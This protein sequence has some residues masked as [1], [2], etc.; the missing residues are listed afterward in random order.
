MSLMRSGTELSQFLKVV[1]Y[2]LLNYFLSNCAHGLLTSGKVNVEANWPKS[3]P[4]PCSEC[5]DI[6]SKAA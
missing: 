2:L 4:A 6:L 3:G 1:F 5:L